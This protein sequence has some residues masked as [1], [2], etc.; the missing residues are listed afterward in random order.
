M[1]EKRVAD[2][3]VVA[4]LPENPRLL[5]ENIFNDSGHLRSVD[6]VDPIVDIGVFFPAHGETMPSG[7]QLLEFTPSG[8]YA[9]LNFGS[10]RTAACFIYYRRGLDKP[11]LVDIGVMYEGTERIMPDATIV[12]ETPGGRVANVN[13]S[14]ARTFLTY[15]RAKPSVPCNELVVTDLC[16]IIPSKNENPPHAFCQIHKT[17]NRGLMGSDVFLCYKKSMNR[18]K[19]ISY[20]P[21]ILHRYPNEDHNDFPLNMCPSVP[22]FCLPMGSTLE[23]W[24][25]VDGE[26][27]VSIYIIK[28]IA[29]IYTIHFTIFIGGTKRDC[30][31]F[32][33]IRSHSQRW[34]V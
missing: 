11:P 10:V 15:R 5:Q 9:D 32:Q 14:T 27:Q 6:A 8:L 12:D 26:A 30:A 18:P 22:L 29:N 19:L 4:G 17:L 1:E 16:I 34:N 3:F 21:E 20:Q 31:Y 33:Y 28:Y 13:N 7:H 24:P 25:Y 23:A 2:Y